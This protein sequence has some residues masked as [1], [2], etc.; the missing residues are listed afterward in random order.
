[1]A[2]RGDPASAIL[3]LEKEVRPD[4]IVM[5]THARTGLRHMVLGSVAE[6][7]VRESTVPVLTLRARPSAA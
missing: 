1:V 2:K 7:T 6:R 4:L 3:E 5:G